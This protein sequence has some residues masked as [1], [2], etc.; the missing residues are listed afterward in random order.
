[1]SPTIHQQGAL[2]LTH[3]AGEREEENSSIPQLDAFVL[4][5][6]AS[7][8]HE[9]KAREKVRVKDPRPVRLYF[10]VV[11]DVFQEGPVKDKITL[12]RKPGRV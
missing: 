10:H 2:G 11:S 8:K 5:R 12:S 1:M 4:R 6:H 3:N 7:D 9:R